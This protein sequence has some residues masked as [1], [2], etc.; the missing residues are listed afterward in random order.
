MPNNSNALHATAESRT[1]GRAW[2]FL[3]NQLIQDVPDEIA[4]CEFD[5]RDTECPLEHWVSCE[6]RL[7]TTEGLVEHA[8][9]R[10][11]GARTS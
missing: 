8:R 2:R 11:P 10:Q 4:A 6:R 1:L 7:Q 3:V 9:R 5:C